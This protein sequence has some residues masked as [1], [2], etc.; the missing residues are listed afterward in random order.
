VDAALYESRHSFVWNYGA[1]LVPLLDPQPGERILDLGCGTGQLTARIADSGARVLGL[2]SSPEM[3]GQARQNYPNLQFTLADAVSF[4]FPREF[5]AVFS[6]A[7]LHWIREPENVIQCVASCLRPEGRFVAEFGGKRNIGRFVT[8]AKASL[9]RRGYSYASPW[10]FPS[11]G[12]YALLLERNGFEVSAAW[13]FDRR[14]KLDDG[15]DAMRDWIQMFGFGVLGSAPKAEWAAIVSD[16]EERL[17]P[18]L[19]VGGQ[20]YMDYVRLRVQAIFRPDLPRS[21]QR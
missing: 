12:E 10:Y 1:D 13:Q 8:A 16:I 19:F 6:N 14:T 18:Y 5:D 15:S 11:I 3:V 2:D 4:S 21:T 7:A 9:E 17:R 20:W